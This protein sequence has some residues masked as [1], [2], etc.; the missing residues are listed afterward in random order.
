[1]HSWT[2][3]FVSPSTHL[4]LIPVLIPPESLT[5]DPTA[6]MFWTLEEYHEVVICIYGYQLVGWPSHLKFSNLSVIEGGTRSLRLLRT[7][8]E[9]GKLKFVK[10]SEPEQVL[11]PA[12]PEM[13]MPAPRGAHLKKRVPHSNTGAVVRPRYQRNGALKTG[14]KT[15]VCVVSDS[16]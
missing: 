10:L 12:H 5:G 14:P 11:A 6:G 16:E 9:A 13:F 7:L 3:S 15:P 2:G 1:M 8:W 4:L